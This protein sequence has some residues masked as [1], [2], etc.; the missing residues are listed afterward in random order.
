MF[1]NDELLKNGKKFG[2]DYFDELLERI[3]EIRASERRAYQKIA[4]AFEQCS[5]DYD[6]GSEETKLFY[7]FVQNKMHFAVTG[8]TAAEIVYDR[9]NSEKA[10]RGLTTLLF[11]TYLGY[12]PTDI[13]PR[14]FTFKQ[15]F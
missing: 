2:I 6:P 1:L 5:A 13:F 3:R 14:A 12:N 8:Q 4:D 9:V 10:H 11:A 15:P 7:A